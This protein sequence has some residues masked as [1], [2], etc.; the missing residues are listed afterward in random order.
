M[1]AVRAHGATL[2]PVD[3]EHNAIFQCLPE[4]VQRGASLD[5]AGVRRILLTASGGPFHR[6]GASE[7]ASVTPEQAVR[8]PN[9]D[10]GPKI[11]VDSATLMNKGLE[12]IEAC[13]LFAVTPDRVEV[14]VHP[15]SVVHSMAE[16][17]DGSVLAQLGTPDM[18]TPIAHALG[19]PERIVSGT[20]RLDFTRLAGLD[21]EAP[22]EQRF[23]ALRLARSALEA[24]GCATA[25]L[26]A[27]NEEAVAAFL[28]HRIGFPEIPALA[29]AALAELDNPPMEN[30]DQVLA[31]DASARAFV[32]ERLPG[33]TREC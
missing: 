13:W 28:D 21:F 20:E 24:G 25:I 3:S 5:S 6:A 19:W 7:L 30:L 8:H 23:P 2:I 9:W 33:E 4:S 22:D 32:R 31:V 1:E 17:A 27:A 12:L 18:R 14:V 10:M 16:Y 29:E 26:N 11:S 15:Q